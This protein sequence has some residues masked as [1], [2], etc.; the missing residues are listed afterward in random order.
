M[1]ALARSVISHRA[2]AR[3]SRR[4]PTEST[5]SSVGAAQSR[6]GRHESHLRSVPV[7]AFSNGLRAWDQ[8]ASAHP[9]TPADSQPRRDRRRS[10]RQGAPRRHQCARA[11]RPL[12]P[13]RSVPRQRR[14]ILREPGIDRSKHR[15]GLVG[16]VAPRLPVRERVSREACEH[17]GPLRPVPVRERSRRE[18]H[19]PAPIRDQAPSAA[20]QAS[21]AP[22]SV[23]RA[24]RS[25]LD[26]NRCRGSLRRA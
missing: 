8:P 1:K 11:L 26:V 10:Q 21:A 23:S 6:A 18:H 14:Q 22:R 7:A 13:A 15:N 24:L 16:Q 20:S 5:A 17:R 4:S 3:R 2:Q 12:D 19:R 9:C 25:L